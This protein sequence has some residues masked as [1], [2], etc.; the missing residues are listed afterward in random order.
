M[1]VSAGVL[2][3]LLLT[4]CLSRVDVAFIKCRIHYDIEQ[5][6]YFLK[7]LIIIAIVP[8]DT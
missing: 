6:S 8:L 3:L 5:L 7:D 1:D 2:L 4:Y